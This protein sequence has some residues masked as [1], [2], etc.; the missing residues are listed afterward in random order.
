M[1]MC[2]GKHSEKKPL[3]EGEALEANNPLEP[4]RQRIHMT[5]AIVGHSTGAWRINRWVVGPNRN[6]IPD[7][8]IC[9]DK[10]SVRED[11]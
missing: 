6:S 3:W 5:L 9:L 10:R 11:I 7:L 2:E 1:C 8:T 4:C